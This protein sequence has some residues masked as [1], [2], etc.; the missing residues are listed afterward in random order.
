MR[1]RESKRRSLGYVF[2][3]LA[4]AVAL[5]SVVATQ[6]PITP[7]PKKLAAGRITIIR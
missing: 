3:V 6:G 7:I 2:L 5:T 1:S 4:A